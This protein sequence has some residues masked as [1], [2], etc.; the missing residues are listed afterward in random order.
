MMI[1]NLKLP[2]PH[3]YE[4]TNISYICLLQNR[5]D[6]NILSDEKHDKLY[7]KLS[8]WNNMSYNIKK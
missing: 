6:R 5:N 7:E 8:E 1:D 3:W 4:Y 2:K